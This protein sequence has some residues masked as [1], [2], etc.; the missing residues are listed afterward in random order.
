MSAKSASSSG[1]GSAPA[2][3]ASRGSRIPANAVS[4]RP[5]AGVR[6]SRREVDDQADHR[7]RFVRRAGGCR[8]RAPRS[9][10]RAPPPGAP[11]G[12]RARPRHA[13]G[14]R[15]RGARTAAR[16]LAPPQ[17]RQREPRLAGSRRAADQH[18]ARADQHGRGVD[19]RAAPSHRRQPHHEARAEHFRRARPAAVGDA[20][21]V[22]GPDAPA[23]RLDDLLGDREAEARSS[24]RTPWCG[25]SV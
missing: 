8:A 3:T 17:Q 12:V 9:G 15:R 19:G 14:R 1:R 5:P 20:R 24:G 16:L 10:P 6:A 11:A 18:G 13:R 25:R 7:H 2:A 4:G 22:L 23:M 21:A